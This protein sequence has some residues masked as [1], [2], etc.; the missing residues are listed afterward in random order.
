[1]PI[2]DPKFVVDPKRAQAGQ[3]VY[4]RSLCLACHGFTMIA[5]GMAPDLRASPVPLSLDA[6]REVVQKGALLPKGMPKF[7]E[8]S[9]DDLI[10]LQHFIRQRARETLQTA[11]KP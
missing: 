4:F 9:D 5:G 11:K 1:V 7:D 2:D 6:F 8:L 10:S 3:A